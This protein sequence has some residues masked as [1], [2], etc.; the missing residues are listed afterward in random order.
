MGGILVKMVECWE[1][2]I[3]KREM[4]CKLKMEMKKIK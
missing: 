1:N 3:M 2:L 4:I